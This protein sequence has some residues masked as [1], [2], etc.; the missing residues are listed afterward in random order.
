VKLMA[1]TATGT[2]EFRLKYRRAYEE[3][4]QLVSL[5]RLQHGSGHALAERFAV[6]VEAIYTEV[7]RRMGNWTDPQ[8]V[9]MAV[10]DAIEGRQPRW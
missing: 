7:I 9:R 2:V 4:L 5:C 8:V 10:E 3:G 6:Q 1:T